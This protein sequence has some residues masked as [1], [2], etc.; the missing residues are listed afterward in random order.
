MNKYRKAF[1]KN[2]ASRFNEFINLVHDGKEEIKA[3][4]LFPHQLYQAF[5]RGE[6]RKAIEAQWMNLP[7]FLAD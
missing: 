4:V 1:L 7:D 3:G 2:D 6:D 5:K